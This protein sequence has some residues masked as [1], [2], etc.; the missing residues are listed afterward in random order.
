M[1]LRRSLWGSPF[2]AFDTLKLNA[3]MSGAEMV[4]CPIMECP[5]IFFNDPNLFKC[6]LGARYETFLLQAMKEN[7]RKQTRSAFTGH[8]A[9]P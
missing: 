5:E 4:N 7:N 9:E 2:S 1:K 6:W 3:M 8:Q